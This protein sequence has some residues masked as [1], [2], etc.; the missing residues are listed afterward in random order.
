ML[1]PSL[2]P[3]LQAVPALRVLALNQRH[4]VVRLDPPEL[5]AGCLPTLR[6]LGALEELTLA[7]DAVVGSEELRR[8]ASGGCAPLKALALQVPGKEHVSAV[9]DLLDPLTALTGLSLQLC[10]GAR[11]QQEGRLAATVARLALLR[12]LQVRS[13]RCEL[14]PAPGALPALT[15]LEMHVA[16]GGLWEEL[17]A[18]E[19]LGRLRKLVL[20][21][22]VTTAGDRGRC[23]EVVRKLPLLEEAEVGSTEWTAEDLG[24]LLPPPEQLKA[25]VLALPSEAAG[26]PRPGVAAAVEQLGRCGIHVTVRRARG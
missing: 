19:G 4:N 11:E 17:H 22:E 15:C 16:R 24:L 14:A 13:I 5:P 18:V 1:G 20:L 21:S 2:G 6:A 7:G 25:L 26:S 12:R 23:M 8:A 9:C 3:S 10:G